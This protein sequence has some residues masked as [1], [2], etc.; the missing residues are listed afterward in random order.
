MENLNEIY[1]ALAK[2]QAEFKVPKKDK[3]AH[4]GDF[5]SIG[6]INEAV[7]DAMTKNGL[8][9]IQ[10]F[11]ML[12]N[13]MFVKTVITHL[14]G[15]SIESA[16]A[17][18]QISHSEKNYFHLLGAAISY[19][20]RYSLQSILGISADDVDDDGD[21][22]NNVSV[23]V[24]NNYDNKTQHIDVKNYST[25]ICKEEVAAL[26]HIFDKL[27]GEQKG[28]AFKAMKE[29]DASEFKKIKSQDFENYAAFVSNLID[30]GDENV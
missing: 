8:S 2:A 11:F 1:T 9:V 21:S 18:P 3:K 28:L 4:Y 30:R 23:S 19:L 15:S 20:R 10:P 22:L 7:R 12:D 16:I 13:V 17:V 14:S 29:I 27:N 26:M 6:S 25:L 24:K 5:A